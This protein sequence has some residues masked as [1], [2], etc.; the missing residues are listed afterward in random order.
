MEINLSA[1]DFFYGKH[2][3][4]K[5]LSANFTPGKLHGICGPNGSGKSTLVKIITG[6][7]KPASGSVTPRF[8][9]P[10]SRARTITVFQQEIPR[11][12]PL[13]AGEIIQLGR[14][15]WPDGNNDQAVIDEAIARL[16][17]QSLIDKPYNHLSGGERQRVL[18]GKALAQDTDILIFDEPE[19]SLDIQHRIKFYELMKHLTA[20]EKCVIVITHDLFLAPS[21]LDKILLLAQGEVVGQGGVDEILQEKNILRSFNCTIP[22]TA[23]YQPKLRI[24]NPI[25]D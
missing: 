2:Q 17:L 6:E 23:R 9:S 13:T 4:L 19:N 11:S 14:Y 3:I 18:L 22:N 8:T 16:D 5:S 15:P 20:Q 12:L 10:A 7:L 21:Y 1:V 25:Q 24:N